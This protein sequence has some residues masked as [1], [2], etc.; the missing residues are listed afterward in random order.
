MKIENDGRILYHST[1]S[2][3]FERKTHGASGYDLYA[4]LGGN[5]PSNAVDI[6]PLER[7]RIPTGIHLAMPLGLEAQVRPRSG[8]AHA[9]GLVAVLGTIDADY[10]G[11]CSV[12]LMNLSKEIATVQHGDRIAQ[13]VFAEVVLPDLVTSIEDE[14]DRIYAWWS[15]AMPT[16]IRVR[17]Y[18]PAVYHIST[19]VPLEG[20]ER[21]AFDARV[22]EHA[23][24]LTEAREGDVSVDGRKTSRAHAPRVVVEGRQLVHVEI[25]RRLVDEAQLTEPAMPSP[26]KPYRLVK[27]D[28]LDELPPS[29]RGTSGWGSTGR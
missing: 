16:G 5:H 24:T 14:D 9:S 21:E 10:R 27:V 4:D 15:T 1:R 11:D 19:W 3:P 25:P 26:T 20:P 7:L 17:G 6:E 22:S 12:Q 8:L 28:S 13:I 29:E 18:S 2:F 23:L